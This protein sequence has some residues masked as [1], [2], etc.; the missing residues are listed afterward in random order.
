MNDVKALF[1]EKSFQINSYILKSIKSLNLN[2][3]EFLLVLYFINESP[4]LD[5]EKIKERIGLKDEEILN[6]YSHLLELSLIETE[7]VK[8]D[9]KMNETINLE[10]FYDKLALN[11]KEEVDVPN[12][13]FY[14]FES[15]LG[16]SLS[17]IEY[18][19]INNWVNNGINTETIESALK[20]A[21]MRGAPNLRYIDKLLYEWI[22]KTNTSEEEYKELFDYDWL[23]DTSE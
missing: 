20:E 22:K 18:E 15:E 19:T 7:V 1:K 14:K 2:L 23:G 17:G 5:L 12:D 9:G 21:I 10:H 11:K 13:I 6:A 16:R 3:D 4:F 8:V